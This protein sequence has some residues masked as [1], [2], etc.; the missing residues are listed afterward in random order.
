MFNYSKNSNL[1]CLP[2]GLSFSLTFHSATELVRNQSVGVI[3][4]ALDTF[5]I[6]PK[7]GT[8]TEDTKGLLLFHGMSF[9]TKNLRYFYGH[10]ETTKRH[11]LNKQGA[12]QEVHSPATEIEIKFPNEHDVGDNVDDM[13]IT[14][15]ERV[16]KALYDRIDQSEKNV[17]LLLRHFLMV[18]AEPKQQSTSMFP[19]SPPSHIPLPPPVTS[20]F[21]SHTPKKKIVNTALVFVICHNSILKDGSVYAKSNDAKENYSIH[22]HPLQV[23]EDCE[24]EDQEGGD[25]PIVVKRFTHR[26]ILGMAEE[27]ALG[28]AKFDGFDRDVDRLFPPEKGLVQ[29]PSS[30][31]MNAKKDHF[32]IPDTK[33]YP[34]EVDYLYECRVTF[35][36]RN[37]HLELKN[38][39]HPFVWITECSF[40][41]GNGDTKLYYLILYD[42]ARDTASA[43]TEGV[44]SS[45]REN[46]TSA[47]ALAALTAKFGNEFTKRQCK[48]NGDS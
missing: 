43:Y 41:P 28:T 12:L 15:A 19:T 30:K 38:S 17:P 10:S 27:G 9:E 23:P 6:N 1:H 5:T 2:F 45:M 22:S 47:T 21:S 39:T 32:C 37:F 8:F 11:A 44:G 29:A 14:S 35:S 16:L 48:S 26:D 33:L 31:K 36:D 3:A 42:N 18:F 46:L 20:S 25:A 7:S 34:L 24:G 4:F 13:N 40:P